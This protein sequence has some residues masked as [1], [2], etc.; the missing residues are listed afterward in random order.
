MQILPRYGGVHHGIFLPSEGA[1]D[2]ALALFSFASLAAYE[3]YREAAKTDP[4]C[5]AAME[6]FAKTGCFR[7]YERQFMRPVL[8]ASTCD[9]ETPAVADLASE[10]PKAPERN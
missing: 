6:F 5:I 9:R 2:V 7:R 10:E 1:S 3:R 4:E 8:P